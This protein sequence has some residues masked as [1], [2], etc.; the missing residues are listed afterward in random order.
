MMSKL[1]NH[2]CHLQNDSLY[3]FV[4]S[5]NISRERCVT[6]TTLKEMDHET[7]TRTKTCR[8]RVEKNTGILNLL[9]LTASFFLALI[10]SIRNKTVATVKEG[11][12]Q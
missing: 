10:G 12:E 4:P 7:Q 2:Y 9:T 8:L 5:Y 6:L 3:H 11:Q 1:K